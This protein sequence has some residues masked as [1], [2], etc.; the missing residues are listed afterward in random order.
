MQN[1]FRLEQT[2]LIRKG[3]AHS[4]GFVLFVAMNAGAFHPSAAAQ[5]VWQQLKDQAQKAKQQMKQGVQPQPTAPAQQPGSRP[6]QSSIATGGAVRLNAGAAYLTTLTFSA[7][8]N[9]LY[10]VFKQAAYKMRIFADGKPL[11]DADSTSPAGFA[12]QTFQ[13]APDGSLLVLT[14]DDKGL[15]RVSITPASSSSVAALFGGSRSVASI[16]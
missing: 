10:W 8:S 13:C 16:H 4:L 14:Q 6:P 9:H 7:D 11:Y 1:P 5:S 15:E 12:P 2:M 3:I